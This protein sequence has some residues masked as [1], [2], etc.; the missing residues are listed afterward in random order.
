M[1]DPGDARAPDP[2]AELVATLL[3]LAPRVAPAALSPDEAAG[4]LRIGRSTLDAYA[5]AGA[6]PPPAKFGAVVRYCRAELDAWLA[7]GCPVAAEW[8]PIWRRLRAEVPRPAR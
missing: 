1:A 2:V 6:V 3:R 7:H 8:A 4:Y 5:L